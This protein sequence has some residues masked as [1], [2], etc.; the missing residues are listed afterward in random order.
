MP[1]IA[2]ALVG[3]VLV[4]TVL[5]CS[6]ARPPRAAETSRVVPVT[7]VRSLAGRW[8]GLVQGRPGAQ[9]DYVELSITNDGRYSLVTHRQIGTATDVGMLVVDGGRA[10]MRSAKNRPGV[11]QLMQDPGGRPALRLDGEI[12]P[13]RPITVMLTRTTR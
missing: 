9:E 10:V 8:G 13:L 5:G 6:T 4:F 11:L 12:D 7:D 3:L 2:H 1:T